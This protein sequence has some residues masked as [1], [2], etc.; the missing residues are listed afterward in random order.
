VWNDI[1]NALHNTVLLA[2]KLQVCLAYFLA[3]YFKVIDDSWMS[4]AAIYQT[5]QIPEFSNAL[6]SFY[7]LFSNGSP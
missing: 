1:K 5:F 4:G 6:I 3:G 2:I 7:P